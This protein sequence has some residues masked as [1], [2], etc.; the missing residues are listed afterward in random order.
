M[1]SRSTSRGSSCFKDDVFEL[2]LPSR[3]F[4]YR[5]EPPLPV[6]VL[7]GNIIGK[8]KKPITTY[9]PKPGVQYPPGPP[10]SPKD[11]PEGRAGGAE[12]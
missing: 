4:W 6:M 2:R 9:V 3:G 1:T 8:V 11:T 7:E 5:L 12:P 10:P